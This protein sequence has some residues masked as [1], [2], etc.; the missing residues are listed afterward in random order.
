VKDFARG[1]MRTYLLLKEKASHWNTDREIKALLE[2]IHSDNGSMA[3]LTGG[4]SADK[5]NALKD[6]PFD[7]P[8]LGK[9]GMA[10][11]RLDQLTIELLL[12]V[13]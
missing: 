9:R 13:R 5:A 12:G 4:Y 8:A 11:E 3:S 1:C 10:Y 7:R 6:H 2:E